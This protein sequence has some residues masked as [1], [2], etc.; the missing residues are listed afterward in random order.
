MFDH[1]CF[2][3]PDGCIFFIQFCFD[4]L[5][6]IF[7]FCLFCSTSFYVLLT[8]HPNIV[9]AFFF[10]NLVHKFFI[11]IKVIKKNKEFVHQV[12]KKNSCCL[13]V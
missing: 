11:L 8:V 7:L 9:I 1:T 2:V 10:A 6:K 5:V 3:E 13:V 4:G 12:G